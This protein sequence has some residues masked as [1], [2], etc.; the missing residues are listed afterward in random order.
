MFLADDFGRE[1]LRGGG[2]GIDGGINAQFRDGALQHDGRVQVRE[3]VGGRGIGQIV[4]RHVDRLEGGDGAF[5]GGGDA[6]LQIAH[7]GGERGLVTDGAGRAAQQRGDFRTGLGE[8]ENV[9][10]EEEH[11][12]VLFV[13]EIFGHGQPLRATR[14]RAPGGSFIWP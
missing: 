3:G 4:R 13:A 9:V 6:F 11:V 12:L 14:R 10:D 8:A 1:R 5:L 7:F 2:E